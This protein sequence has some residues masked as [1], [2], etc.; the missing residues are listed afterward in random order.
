MIRA[1][2]FSH[3]KNVKMTIA[4]GNLSKK[5][6]ANNRNLIIENVVKLTKLVSEKS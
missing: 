6:S 4:Q 1:L 5:S 3:N 2:I